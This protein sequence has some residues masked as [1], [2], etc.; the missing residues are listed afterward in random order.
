MY[1]EDYA[2]T[3]AQ[4]IKKHQQATAREALRLLRLPSWWLPS[5]VAR[6]A[7]VRQ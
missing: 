7:R 6:A 4:R 3:L 2:L 1:D 5:P